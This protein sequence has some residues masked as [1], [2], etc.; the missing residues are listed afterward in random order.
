MR[1][2]IANLTYAFKCSAPTTVTLL[3]AFCC[4]LW[5]TSWLHLLVGCSL[6]RPRRCLHQVRKFA[7]PAMRPAFVISVPTAGVPHTRNSRSTTR[8]SLQAHTHTVTMRPQIQRASTPDS[9]HPRACPQTAA[10]GWHTPDSLAQLSASAC[11]GQQDTAGESSHQ[12]LHSTRL[13]HSQTAHS[14]IQ[15]NAA[16]T[17]LRGS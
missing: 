4:M 6:R 1:T 3:V 13:A 8:L 15:H 7:F 9:G 12:R 17:S 14:K 5:A 10:L 16:R 2:A 11:S